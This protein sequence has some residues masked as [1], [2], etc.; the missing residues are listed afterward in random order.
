MNKFVAETLKDKIVANMR[1]SLANCKQLVR[2]IAPSGNL[3]LVL[4]L[5]ELRRQGITFIA[6]YVLQRVIEEPGISQFQLRRET[7]LE[8]YEISRDCK[9]LAA[10]ELIKTGRAT[11]DRRV[12]ALR[13][14]SRGKKIRGQ[15]LS[16]AAKH[17]QKG[18]SIDDSFRGSGE[19]RRL[20]EATESFQ[21]GNRTLL[22]SLQLSF[23]DTYPTEMNS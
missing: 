13:P 8:N 5:Q 22:G 12:R 19:N 7:G 1:V 20:T 16:E 6:F 15:I 14:T 17:L 9:F 18:L 23:F 2:V 21:L 4:L 3:F 10:S 11:E